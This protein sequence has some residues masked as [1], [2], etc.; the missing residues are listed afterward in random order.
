MHCEEPKLCF[1][2]IIATAVLADSGSA[3]VALV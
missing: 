3:A 1:V 2:L